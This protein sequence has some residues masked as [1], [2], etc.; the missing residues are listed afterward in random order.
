MGLKKI[1]PLRGRVLVAYLSVRPVLLLQSA[2]RLCTRITGPA[3][4]CF[5][6]YTVGDSQLETP[7]LYRG[8]S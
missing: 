8:A 2:G 5:A 1:T 3:R 7:R 4:I 6:A